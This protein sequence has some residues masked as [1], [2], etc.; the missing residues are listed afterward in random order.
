[1]GLKDQLGVVPIGG[2]LTA[3]EAA[4]GKMASAFLLAAAAKDVGGGME[5]V[6][7]AEPVLTPMTTVAGTILMSNGNNV[8]QRRSNNVTATVVV[9][10]AA[11]NASRT[12]DKDVLDKPTEVDGDI[13]N[14]VGSKALTIITNSSSSKARKKPKSKITKQHGGNT[15]PVVDDELTSIVAVAASASSIGGHESTN[16]PRR[17]SP[18]RRS[19]TNELSPSAS[20]EPTPSNDTTQQQQQQQQSRL[21]PLASP[22][23]PPTSKHFDVLSLQPLES[24]AT[25]K[26]KYVQLHCKG[27]RKELLT[28]RGSSD[29]AQALGLD[30]KII[31]AMCERT[32][33]GCGG[34]VGGSSDC[35][36]QETFSLAYASNRIA[37]RSYQYG[38]HV[39]DWWSV[40]DKEE[41]E[42]SAMNDTEERG[43]G[44]RKGRETYYERLARWEKTFQKEQQ[45]EQNHIAELALH[46]KPPTKEI[47]LKNISSMDDT[48]ITKSLHPDS[49][50]TVVQPNQLW[51]TKKFNNGD[52]C[53]IC[54]EKSAQIVFQP[55]QHCLVCA[56]CVQNGYCPKFCPSCRI[57]ITSTCQPTYLK[58]VRPRIYTTQLLL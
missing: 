42:D 7:E 6:E 49:L 52:N 51:T 43:G 26:K 25:H 34:S 23:Y 15:P 11:A 40:E 48:A 50:V 5:E 54:Q 44:L 24:T 31:S 58:L 35:P 55:C 4:E 3:K 38:I 39:E 22:Y 32:K 41:E 14:D 28:F 10:A 36:V 56:Q 37:P 57:N 20:L 13:E 46:E 45:R 9:A 12:E 29:A 21:Q 47:A 30:R 53:V 19:L 17:H 8:H 18:I 27:S 16:R 33:K 2:G 1:M